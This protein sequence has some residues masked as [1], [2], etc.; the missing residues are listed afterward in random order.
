MPIR[1]FL[2]TN[3]V[4]DHDTNKLRFRVPLD[5]LGN[6]LNNMGNFPFK[7]P[8]EHRY[9]GR[10]LVVRGTNSTYVPDDLLPLVG[11]FFPRFE[12]CDIDAGH[13]VISEKPEEFRRGALQ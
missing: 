12:L 1:Q 3:L 8:A 4:R 9:D 13:W 6:A 2:L 10:T 7:D 11:Q 5:I